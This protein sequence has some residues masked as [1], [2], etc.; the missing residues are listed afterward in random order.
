MTN[1]VNF[2]SLNVCIDSVGL[3]RKITN[4]QNIQTY[5]QKKKTGIAIIAVTSKDVRQAG[6]KYAIRGTIDIPTAQNTNDPIP[7]QERYFSSVNS[8]SMGKLVQFRNP[9]KNVD[10]C[11]YRS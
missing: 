10:H 5:H 6:T 7:I 8:V 9:V 3:A 4:A 11:K 1:S 2:G